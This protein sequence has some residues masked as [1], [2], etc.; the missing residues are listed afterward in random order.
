MVNEMLL[1]LFNAALTVKCRLHPKGCK[2]IRELTMLKFILALI[3][4]GNIRPW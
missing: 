1:P 4:G 2:K 3:Y